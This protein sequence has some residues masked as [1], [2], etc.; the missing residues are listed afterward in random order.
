VLNTEVTCALSAGGGPAGVVELRKNLFEAGVFNPASVIELLVEGPLNRLAVVDGVEA[1]PNIPGLGVCLFKP[2]NNP[3]CEEGGFSLPES[4]GPPSSFFWLKPP[5]L[6]LAEPN[7]FPVDGAE[8]VVAVVDPKKGLGGPL[9]APKDGIVVP[10]VAVPNIDPACVAPVLGV[11][12]GLAPAPVVTPPPNKVDAGFDVA[13][14][15]WPKIEEVA[16]VPLRG[17]RL[18]PAPPCE[19]GFED[20]FKPVLAFLSPPFPPLPKLNAMFL[21]EAD[22]VELCMDEVRKVKATPA[23]LWAV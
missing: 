3:P 6:A 4:V 5:K 19:K 17:K 22:L 20:E 14:E 12:K 18:L 10:E 23:S 16:G 1:E 7:R 13:V 11:P 8:V 15:D 9:V 2:A 21:S